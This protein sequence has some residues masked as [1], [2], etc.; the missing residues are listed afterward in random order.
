MSEAPRRLVAI[1]RVGLTLGKERTVRQIKTGSMRRT[2]QWFAAAAVSALSVGTLAACA[3][4][5]PTHPTNFETQN[6][7]WGSCASDWLL[8]SD[9]TSDQ[10]LA[11]THDCTT[12]FVPAMYDKPQS[13]HDFK[14]ALVRRHATDTRLGT[15]FINPGGPGVSGVDELQW[16]TFPAE[17]TKHYDIIGFDPRGVA[18]SNFAD[19]SEIHCSNATDYATYFAAPSTAHN[20]REYLAGLHLWNRN[21]AQCVKTNPLWHTMST[22]NVVKDLEIMRKVITGDEPLNFL[23]SSYGTTIAA[24]YI[25]LYPKHVG[26]IM[27]DSPTSSEPATMASQVADARSFE[28]KLMGWIKGYATH[29]KMSVAAVKKLLLQIRKWGDDDKLVGFAG[30]ELLDAKNH[31]FR[32]NEGLFLHGIEALAYKSD[33]SAQDYFNAGLDDLVSSKWNGTFEGLALALDGYDTDAL[34]DRTSF[35]TSDIVRDNSYEVMVIVDELDV[36]WPAQPAALSA[37]I[38][39]AVAKASP[40]WTKLSASPDD[41]TYDGKETYKDFIDFALEDPKIPDPPSGVPDRVNNSGKAVLVVGSRHESVTPYAFA[42]RTARQLKS[43]LVTVEGGEHAPLAGFTSPCLNKIF[44]D[45][46]LHD[47]LPADGTSCLP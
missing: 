28:N 23:G 33:T 26:H 47:R 10:F 3:P 43:P 13:G 1:V 14:L 18:H 44:V 9:Q 20:D 39:A 12:V 40:F 7:V 21:V 15:L 6:I 29:A 27:L 8:S 32:S 46:L 25:G 35:K 36:N 2:R 22:R 42:V 45:Y 34:W 24:T 41:Y 11:S 19:G 38:D 37:R 31:A 4:A 16:Q 17:V 5:A 30:M